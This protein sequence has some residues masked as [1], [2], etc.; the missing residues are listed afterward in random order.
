MNQQEWLD[1]VNG[2]LFLLDAEDPAEWDKVKWFFMSG[3]T[4]EEAV[5]NLL[6]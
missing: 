1:W 3:F 4:P 6:E 5:K 2:Y